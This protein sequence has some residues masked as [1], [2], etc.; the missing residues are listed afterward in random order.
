MDGER[1]VSS[2]IGIVLLVAVTVI[3]AGVLATFALDFGESTEA[4]PPAAFSSE[5][6]EKFLVATGS[7]RGDFWALTIEYEGGEAI[8]EERVEVRINGETAYG[9]ANTS[10]GV[11]NDPKCHEAVR[12]WNGSGTITASNQITVVHK[13]SQD[14]SEGDGYDICTESHSN[15]P[16]GVDED[17]P[18]KSLL[19]GD[20]TYNS[21]PIEHQLT[22]GD[23]VQVVWASESGGTTVKL[24]EETIH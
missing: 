8:A 16:G 11:C 13:D 17:N 12:L 3:L 24:F 7:N 2:V 14:M 5:Q 22:S 4:A 21:N 9:V 6:T 15:C 10:R 19:Y 20:G 18:D 23:T 1:A